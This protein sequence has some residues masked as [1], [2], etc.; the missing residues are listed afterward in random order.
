MRKPNFLPVIVLAALLCGAAAAQSAPWIPDLPSSETD[1]IIGVED[2]L[3]IG[4]WGETGLNATVFVRP[5]GKITF[6]LV[7]DIRVA[8]LT[9]DQ[10]REA[11]GTRLANFIRDPNVTVIVDQINSFR[12]YVLGE[13]AIQGVLDFNRPVRVLQAIS[14]AGGF[15][16]FSKREIIILRQ[17]GDSERRI[18]INY[19]RL[20]SGESGE[21]NLFLQPGDTLLVN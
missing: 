18:T 19:K 3:T 20:M 7:N 9:P 14:I 21:N 11:V 10:V 2:I 1:Y 6:P 8:G 12:V 4:V 16:Q 5:D 15:T 13:V 17:E